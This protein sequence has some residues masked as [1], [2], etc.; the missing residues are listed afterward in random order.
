MHKFRRGL[1][2]LTH[3]PRFSTPKQPDTV[4]RVQPWEKG[5]PWEWEGVM[6]DTSL[7]LKCGPCMSLT[8]YILSYMKMQEFYF[9]KRGGSLALDSAGPPGIQ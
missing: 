6:G 3:A 2:P 8:H 1:P 4:N 7:I 5:K 9:E